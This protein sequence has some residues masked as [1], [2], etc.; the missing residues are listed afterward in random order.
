MYH[1]VRE[2]K[3]NQVSVEQWGPYSDL[4]AARVQANRA[5]S[6]PALVV[7]MDSVTIF[8]DGKIVERFHVGGEHG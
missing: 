8:R 1:V 2:R 5:L 4:D 3:G 7:G 6:I